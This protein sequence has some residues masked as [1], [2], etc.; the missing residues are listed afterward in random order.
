MSGRGVDNARAAAVRP[1]SARRAC[2]DSARA[3]DCVSTQVHLHVGFAAVV[4]H[5]LC[6]GLRAVVRRQLRPGFG[7]DSPR[8][9]G[10][11]GATARARQ[12]ANSTLFSTTNT[13]VL[14]RLQ[15]LFNRLERPSA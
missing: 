9:T 11:D 6:A 4:R 12:S 2:P 8:R 14:G 13:F 1:K 7:P 15:R 10:P 5:D 3:V